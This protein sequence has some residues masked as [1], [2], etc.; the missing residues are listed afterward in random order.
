MAEKA[1]KTA[2]AVKKEKKPFFLVRFFRW[3]KKFFRDTYTEM[4]KVVWPS[5]KQVIN[6]TVVVL[7]VVLLSAVVIFILDAVF[8]FGLSTV[9]DLLAK[10]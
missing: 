1:E 7:V 10:V 6:N 4:K 5:K 9:L 3:I 2:K 8:G